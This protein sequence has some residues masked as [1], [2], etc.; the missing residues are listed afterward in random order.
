MPT[1]TYKTELKVPNGI[2]C[3][4]CI[5]KEAKVSQPYCTLFWKNLFWKHADSGAPQDLVKCR[6]CWNAI[7]DALSKE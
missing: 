6:E 4:G 2:Y 5:R 3:G 1:I 7:Y